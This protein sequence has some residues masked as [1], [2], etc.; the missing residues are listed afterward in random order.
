[1]CKAARRHRRALAR[2]HRNEVRFART[3][4]EERVSQRAQAGDKW[5]ERRM[6]HTADLQKMASEI[7]LE[8]AQ[9]R[10]QQMKRRWDKMEEERLVRQ[11]N[12]RVVMLERLRPLSALGTDVAALLTTTL[13]SPMEQRMGAIADIH[14]VRSRKQRSDMHV[15]L[16][17]SKE[18]QQLSDLGCTRTTAENKAE[19]HWLMKLEK[20]GLSKHGSILDPPPLGISMYDDQD[21]LQEPL[22]EQAAYEDD[23]SAQARFNAQAQQFSEMQSYDQEH[24]AYERD[25]NRA[26]SAEPAYEPMEPIEPMESME[27][28][29]PMEP[30]EQ[31]IEEPMGQTAAHDITPDPASEE[32]AED[33]D[34]DLN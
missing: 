18:K 11:Q 4:E 30:M 16:A 27:P 28:M 23:Q 7:K 20:K 9:L 25:Q 33:Y 12:N 3:L 24:E 8:N 26:A 2:Q 17:R 1:M 13:P 6:C 21:Y 15:A 32:E 31:T 5:I 22:Q 14:A 34:E 29:E 19:Q 10:Q